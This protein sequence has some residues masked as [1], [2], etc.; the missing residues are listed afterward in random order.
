[1]HNI[2]N[3]KTGPRAGATPAM[4]FS[5]VY[6]QTGGLCQYSPD[7][8][9]FAVAAEHRLIIRDADTMAVRRV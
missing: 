7:G 9:S 4:E 6:V 1:M 2:T 5:D 3:L 8:A